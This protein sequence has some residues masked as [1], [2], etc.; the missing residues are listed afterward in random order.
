MDVPILGKQM[1]ARLVVPE[2]HYR[3]P[4]ASA[5]AGAVYTAN[6]AVF[7]PFELDSAQQLAQIA[8]LVT[9][10]SGNIDV[11]IYTRA[12]TRLVSA[13]STAMGAA[14]IQVFNTTDIVL[15]RGRYL[16]GFAI[17][18]A[19]GTIAEVTPLGGA[20]AGAVA[21]IGAFKQATAFPL[22]ATATL[23]TPTRTTVP[24]IGLEFS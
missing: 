1:P 5:A 11:G 21:L 17:S 19:T 24:L 23:A 3:D 16:V 14:G 4:N 22:P 13:G 2:I 6:D 20:S 15:G 7:V 8:L 10:Q 9:V 12:G 18:N